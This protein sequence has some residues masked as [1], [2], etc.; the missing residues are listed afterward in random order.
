MNKINEINEHFKSTD[1]VKN[2]SATIEKL[3]RVAMLAGAIIDID[4]ETKV[5]T[6]PRRS[7]HYFLST[8]FTDEKNGKI[9]DVTF[10]SVGDYKPDA[11]TEDHAKHDKLT[12]RLRE[13]DGKGGAISDNW[14]LIGVV[15]HGD[16]VPEYSLTGNGNEHDVSR[17][18]SE[19]EAEQILPLLETRL[20]YLAVTQATSN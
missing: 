5:V 18:I 9:I 13:N 16:A 3:D 6:D 17:Y 2:E 12:V 15:A 20:A 11:T 8:S 1:G 7:G 19:E 14:P 4:P 10:G